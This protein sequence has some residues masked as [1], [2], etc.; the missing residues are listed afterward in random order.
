MRPFCEID[1]TQNPSLLSI[2]THPYPLQKEVAIRGS[3]GP[4][5]RTSKRMETTFLIVIYAPLILQPTL[6]LLDSPS[7]PPFYRYSDLKALPSGAL[8]AAR[9]RGAVR[10]MPERG[11]F[12]FPLE[13][14][15][16]VY[17][18]IAS[19]L[20]ITV[21][22]YSFL[23]AIAHQQGWFLVRSE[24]LLDQ[25][26]R[27]DTTSSMQV[28]S[29]KKGSSSLTMQRKLLLDSPTV[30]EIEVGSLRLC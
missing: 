30:L 25:Y 4:S 18:A 7:L 16:L 15:R 5:S 24:P 17:E 29:N 27:L 26:H 8:H 13:L 20:V 28:M 23:Y 21:E 3:R 12:D 9:C 14:R 10:A 1:R 2:D 11:F 22:Q 19:N 6:L